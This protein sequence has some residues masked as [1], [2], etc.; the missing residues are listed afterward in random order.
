MKMR[1]ALLFP[2]V[3]LAGC[4]IT[5]QEASNPE[6]VAQQSV[7]LIQQHTDGTNIMKQRAKAQWAMRTPSPLSQ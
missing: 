4:S 1:M 6:T 3:M 7:P 5:P 2:L